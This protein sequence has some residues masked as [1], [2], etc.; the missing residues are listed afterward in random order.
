M[1][2]YRSLSFR[3]V[4]WL[5]E[6]PPFPSPLTKQIVLQSWAV[7]D[8]DSE[9]LM[10]RRAVRGGVGASQ[11]TC[12]WRLDVDGALCHAEKIPEMYMRVFFL[13]R[14]DTGIIV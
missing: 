11:V 3:C 2:A 8:G 1:T 10:E 4:C 7:S 9:C 5:S 6:S 12:Y 13:G 14:P